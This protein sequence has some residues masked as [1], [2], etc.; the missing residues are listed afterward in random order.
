MGCISDNT[1][2][3]FTYEFKKVPYLGQ[4]YLLPKIH[5]RLENVHGRPI[6]S[7]CGNPT[8]KASEIFNFHLQRI[9]QNGA[10]Y[11]KDSNDF[12]SNIKNIDIP[13]DAFPV[14]ADF[15]GL[16]PRIPHA[17]GLSALAET[18]DKRTRK[19]IST[20]NLTKMAEFILKNNFFEFGTN[21]FQQISGTAVGTKF[22]PSYECIFNDQREA[23]F[24]ENQ[25]LKPL[26]EFYY[27]DEVFFI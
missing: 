10:S 3:Y 6:I 13:N 20:E 5:K 4:F 9:M 2:K 1:L 21:V 15:F 11:I 19:E 24:L 12:K 22:A 23:K 18:L 7:N 25:N 17:A 16:Y 26:I 27:I 14:T 8:E